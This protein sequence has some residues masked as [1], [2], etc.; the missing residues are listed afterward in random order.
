[1]A[2]HLLLD[3]LQSKGTSPSEITLQQA[4]EMTYIN[5][6]LQGSPAAKAKLSKHL[7]QTSCML[8]LHEWY[9]VQATIS[10]II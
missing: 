2:I 6:L 3:L 10:I 8:H 5:I 4:K 1:M 7:E 9:H